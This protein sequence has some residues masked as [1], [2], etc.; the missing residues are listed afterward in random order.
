M[1]IIGMFNKFS[2]DF[3]LPDL[4]A[5]AGSSNLYAIRQIFDKIVLTAIEKS[6]VGVP[7]TGRNVQNSSIIGLWRKQR[8]EVP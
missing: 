1:F 6:H 5:M 4:A 2:R 7:E 8:L 3:K